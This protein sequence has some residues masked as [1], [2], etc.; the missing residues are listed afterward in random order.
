[1]AHS[2]CGNKFL[3]TAYL[4]TL[5]RAPQLLMY[6]NIILLNAVL[7]GFPLGVRATLRRIVSASFGGVGFGLERDG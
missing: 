4:Q 5:N 7:E 6:T 1:M 2:L 3:L